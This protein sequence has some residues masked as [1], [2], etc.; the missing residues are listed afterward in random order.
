MKKKK[1]IQQ[2]KDE[3]LVT[4]GD[5]IF[6]VVKKGSKAEKILSASS[7]CLEN[8]PKAMWILEIEEY[9]NTAGIL[10]QEF[11]YTIHKKNKVC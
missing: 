2:L 7:Y 8:N 5:K 10:K 11:N 1:S 6:A 3:G 9:C 4:T